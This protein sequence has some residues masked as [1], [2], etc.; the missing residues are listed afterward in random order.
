MILLLAVMIGLLAGLARAG[1]RGRRLMCP[2]LR[3]VW[4]V[5]VAFFPQW[6]AFYLPA[7]CKWIPR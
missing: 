1:Y 2:N 5:P 6:L 3:L 7:A 4:L